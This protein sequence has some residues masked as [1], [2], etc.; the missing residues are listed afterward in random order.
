MEGKTEASAQPRI[1]GTRAAVPVQGDGIPQTQLCDLAFQPAAVH[2][3]AADAVTD[4]GQ[5]AAPLPQHGQG[6]QHN[7]VV[8]VAVEFPHRHEEKILLA[9]PQPVAAVPPLLRRQRAEHP[10]VQPTPG[11]LYTAPFFFSRNFRALR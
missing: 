3:V 9:D 4:R 7:A 1:S 6:L 11:I 5:I 8:F 2:P 10:R